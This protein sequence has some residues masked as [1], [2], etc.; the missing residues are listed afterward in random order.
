M[1]TMSQFFGEGNA[2]YKFQLF[3]TSGTWVKPANMIGDTVLVTA[4]GGGGG[5]IVATASNPYGY[6]ARSGEAVQ[7]LP[8]TVAGN[9][10]V[11]IGSGGA[12]SAPAAGFAEGGAGGN[13]SFGALTVRG[14]SGAKTGNSSVSNSDAVGLNGVVIDYPDGIFV[15]P[16]T[17]G[18]PFGANGGAYSASSTAFAA[19]GAGA[20]GL[21]LGNTVVGGGS[22]TGSSGGRGHGYGAGGGT[23]STSNAVNAGVDGA[24]LVEWWENP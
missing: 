13:T 18:G 8:F 2:V 6:G 10:T 5:G 17:H 15:P 9:Q 20:G 23:S 14:G 3:T 1:S 12:E 21:R 19:C 22:V 4:I 24:V 16:Q 7:R 11:T